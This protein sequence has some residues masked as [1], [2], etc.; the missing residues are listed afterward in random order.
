MVSVGLWLVV[1]GGVGVVV[2]GGGEVVVGVR[3]VED[4]VALYENP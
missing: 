2:C 3:D 1:V 4:V